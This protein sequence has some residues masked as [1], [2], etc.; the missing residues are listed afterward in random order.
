MSLADTPFK[1]PRCGKIFEDGQYL[2][3]LNHQEKCKK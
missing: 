1:C 3:F 2:N